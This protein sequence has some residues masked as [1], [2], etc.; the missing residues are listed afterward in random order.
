MPLCRH[1]K[2]SVVDHLIIPEIIKFVFNS[3][4]FIRTV[5]KF[6]LCSMDDIFLP[7][8]NMKGDFSSILLFVSNEKIDDQSDKTVVNIYIKF[9]DKVDW[10]G[11]VE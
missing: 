4:S 1:K 11:A 6:R 10:A 8:E 9:S 7:L 3:A 5:D 2:G